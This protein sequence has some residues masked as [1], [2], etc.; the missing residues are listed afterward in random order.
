MYRF[1][2]IRGLIVIYLLNAYRRYLDVRQDLETAMPCA[3]MLY[4]GARVHHGH[5][6]VALQ[7]I[8]GYRYT[9]LTVETK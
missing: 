2:P 1:V 7:Y 6:I 8:S 4:N 3:V 5:A 9:Q